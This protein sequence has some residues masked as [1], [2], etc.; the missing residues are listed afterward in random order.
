MLGVSP[1]VVRL[2]RRSGRTGSGWA[3]GV[4]SQQPTVL[5][6]LLDE[7]CLRWGEDS[8]FSPEHT[9]QAVGTPSGLNTWVALAFSGIY[10]S[11]V[12]EKINTVGLASNPGVYV[13]PLCTILFNVLVWLFCVCEQYFLLFPLYLYNPYIT[14]KNSN[15]I[16]FSTPAM[17]NNYL[18]RYAPAF[19]SR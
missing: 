15:P 4:P 7:F 14:L 5:C 10:V 12:E 9:C 6:L 8:D 1:G 13:E 18:I 17:L 3:G 2:G 11:W 16:V 19:V